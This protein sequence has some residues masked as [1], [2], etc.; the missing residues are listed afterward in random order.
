MQRL[1]DFF[2][3][4]FLVLYFI[5]AAVLMVGFVRAAAAVE[6]DNVV[7]VSDGFTSKKTG[8]RVQM[9]LLSLSPPSC[10]ASGR[11]ALHTERVDTESG[12]D[13]VVPFCWKPASD[14]AKIAGIRIYTPG[15][16]PS[17][18]DN[19]FTIPLENFSKPKN[20]ISL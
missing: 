16:D 2:A 18:D 3:R 13:Q 1:I 14:G 19:A 11:L 6:I 7:A 15:S 8:A 20:L 10:K 17:S 4:R 5:A 9:I 12:K